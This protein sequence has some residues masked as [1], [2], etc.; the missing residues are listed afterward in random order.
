MAQTSADDA[1]LVQKLNT[2]YA[3]LLHELRK[4]IIAQDAVVEQVGPT[5]TIAP[6]LDAFHAAFDPQDLA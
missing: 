5:A 1:V 3:Q 4:V 6:N 2:G